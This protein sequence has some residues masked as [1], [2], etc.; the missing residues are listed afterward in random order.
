MP[1]NADFLAP[2][3]A[4]LDA[5]GVDLILAYADDRA[6]LADVLTGLGLPDHAA[7]LARMQ[8]RNLAGPTRV[9]TPE[10]RA[11]A[12]QRRALAVLDK[13]PNVPPDPGDEMPFSMD[14]LE[15]TIRL[16]ADSADLGDA[17]VLYAVED[18][19]G[20]LQPDTV[21]LLVKILRQVR[22]VDAVNLL[23][24]ADAGIRAAIRDALIRHL[25]REHRKE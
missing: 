25:E 8:A 12:L 13:V 19:V 9:P 14:A 20:T 4:D 18:L 21:R 16:K 23:V 22:R 2:D 3:P 1:K 15:R 7:V 17:W 10:Q 24:D 5:D 6:Y 11:A